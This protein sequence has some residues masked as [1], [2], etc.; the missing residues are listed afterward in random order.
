MRRRVLL[1]PALLERPSRLA[2][3]SAAF[4][5]IDPQVRQRR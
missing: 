2:P 1:R 3:R 5:E 4:D